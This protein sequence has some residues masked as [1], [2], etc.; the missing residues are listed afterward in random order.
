RLAEA[1]AGEPLVRDLVDG[2]PPE[3]AVAVLRTLAG[4]ANLHRNARVIGHAIAR[5]QR[6]V[7]ALKTYS[8]L[9]EEPARVAVDLHEGL[10]TT[11]TL[12]DYAL[13]DIT[14]VRRFG[15]LPPIKVFVDELN[16][17]WTNLIHNAV[18]ALG[19]KGTIEIA[20]ESATRRR[21]DVDVPGAVVRVI[22]DGPGI[23]PDVMPRIF[24]PFFTTKP[25][26]EGTGLGLGIVS[27]IVAK[28]GGEVGCASEPG[29]TVFEVWLPA[30]EPAADAAPADAAPAARE[31][32]PT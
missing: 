18:Q 1:G 31:A 32:P 7:G 13:R 24:E 16:Q 4:L 15:S 26:G 27:Q 17:V 25:K 19:G 29:R 12:F 28:H 2:R 6:I 9:D 8:H 14:L 20:T 21:G 11:L 30:D 5:I 23:P 22:D 3:A 10:E